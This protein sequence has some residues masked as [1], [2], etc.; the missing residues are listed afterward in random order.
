MQQDY[1]ATCTD[2]GITLQE[3]PGLHP[4][5]YGAYPRK[6]A[7]YVRERRIISLPFAIRS[8]TGLPAQIIGLQDRGY[9]RE[10]LKAD[11]VIFDFATIQDRA[12]ILEPHLPPEGIEFVV[13]NGQLTVD[14]GETTGLLPGQ[15]LVRSGASR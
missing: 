9:L 1:T 12:T 2:A 4:R 6:I 10:G 13:T 14:A 15:V 8:S 3:R 11:L 7:H 5:Y